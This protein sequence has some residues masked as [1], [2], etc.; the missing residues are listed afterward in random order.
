MHIL[1]I[2]SSRISDPGH[3]RLCAK[4][5]LELIFGKMGLLIEHFLQL[6]FC[7]ELFFQ[8]GFVKMELLSA[9]LKF[10]EIHLEFCHQS[11]I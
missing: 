3:L 5:H 4:N 2:S 10:Y 9:F 11:I 7:L 6:E 1:L 8:D